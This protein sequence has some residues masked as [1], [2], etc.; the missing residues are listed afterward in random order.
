MNPNLDEML[1]RFLAD[2][3]HQPI[4]KLRRFIVANCGP[5]DVFEY[6]TSKVAA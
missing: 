4:T 3:K 1:Q 2:L 6:E 5:W